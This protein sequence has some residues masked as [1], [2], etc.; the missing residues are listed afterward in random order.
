[1]ADE[2]IAERNEWRIAAIAYAL[3]GLGL[4]GVL[5]PSIVALVIN[6]IK[7]NE[8]TPLYASHHR[9]MI[10]TFWWGLLWV[11]VGLVLV[12]AIVGWMIL[13]AAV[14]WWIYRLVRGVLALSE[15][16]SVP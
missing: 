14:I 16:R 5:L 8:A 9:W 13:L 12:L 4:F 6:Y 15:N 10:R 7:A 3:Y 1:M 2:Q 11:V